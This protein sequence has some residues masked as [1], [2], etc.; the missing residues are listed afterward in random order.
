M[1]PGS[2]TFYRGLLININNIISLWVQF[3][4]SF[5]LGLSLCSKEI[6]GKLWS[7]IRLRGEQ[8]LSKF[9]LSCSDSFVFF[10]SIVEKLCLSLTGGCSTFTLDLLSLLIGKCIISSLILLI[11]LFEI[12]KSFFL[13]RIVENQNLL[14]DIK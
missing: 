12:S 11:K 7:L 13:Q 4:F 1:T 10:S 9:V 2:I 5:C 6:F 3:P 8:I 14:L